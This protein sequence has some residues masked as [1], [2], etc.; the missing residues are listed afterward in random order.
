MS[1]ASRKSEDLTQRMY[2][3]LSNLFDESGV[4]L[5]NVNSNLVNDG[6][7]LMF[8]FEGRKYVL[9][10]E[11]RSRIE[12]FG[13][14]DPMVSFF[15]LAV[16]VGDRF[17]EDVVSDIRGCF[18]SKNKTN[19]RVYRKQ[20]G[21]PMKHPLTHTMVGYEAAIHDMDGYEGVKICVPLRKIPKGERGGLSEKLFR[22]VRDEFINP[23]H[24]IS[25]RAYE[26]SN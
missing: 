21:E 17:R 16:G 12:D 14:E 10:F 18:D 26:G 3:W 15:I 20:F 13:E 1:K 9:G 5:P 7:N 23:L 24:G 19:R 4:S 11:R 6:D 25:K 8:T 2:N 22:R